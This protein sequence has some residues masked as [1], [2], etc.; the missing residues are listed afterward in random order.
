M[1]SQTQWGDV[2]II[3]PAYNE[4]KNIGRVIAE[5]HQV[6]ADCSILVVDDGSMDGTAKA[7]RTAGAKVAR[8]PFN[9]GYGVALQTGYKY[10]WTHHY[11]YVIQMDADGQHDANSIPDL[12]QAI[13]TGE[14]DLVIGSRFLAESRLN[15]KIG[16]TRYWACLER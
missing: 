13:K 12:L 15:Y 7:A 8:L 4:Q 9:L 6:C 10:A 16:L 11:D 14:S 1:S 5:I 2:L 3:I